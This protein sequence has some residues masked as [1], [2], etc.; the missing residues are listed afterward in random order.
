MA[1]NNSE[2]RKDRTSTHPFVAGRST[3]WRIASNS[4]NRVGFEP[5][6]LPGGS[7]F[8]ARLL[9]QFAYLFLFGPYGAF[10]KSEG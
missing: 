1:P 8:T 10:A 9:R 2:A 5:T 6:G 7:E 3:D 4:V